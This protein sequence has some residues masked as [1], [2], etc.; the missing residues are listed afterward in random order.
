LSADGTAEV[1]ITAD[2]VEMQ[3]AVGIL[4]EDGIEGIVRDLHMSSY[5]MNV[6]LLGELRL[7]VAAGMADEARRILLAAVEDGALGEGVV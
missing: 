6:G 5:P 3:V 1:F 2:P 7:V 4:E